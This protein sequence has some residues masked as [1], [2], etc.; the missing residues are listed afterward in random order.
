LYKWNNSTIGDKSE[1]L[2][3]MLKEGDHANALILV[4][5][6]M[7][8]NYKDNFKMT[9]LMYSSG[10]GYSDVCWTLLSKGANLDLQTTKR[11]TA[12]ILASQNGHKDPVRFLLDSGANLN[13][14]TTSGEKAL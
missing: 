10:K 3:K 1:K 14:L 2:I 4:S 13:K 8:V 11:Q 7:E 6:I 12:L 5:D 9:L